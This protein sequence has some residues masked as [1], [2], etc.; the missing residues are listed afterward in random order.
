[1]FRKMM[2][3]F[4]LMAACGL[5]A[6][7]VMIDGVKPGVS[8]MDLAA[9]KEY[10]KNMNLPLFLD[11]TGSDWCGWCKLMQKNVFTKKE[12]TDWAKSRLVLVTID[13]PQN[14]GIVPEKYRE[15]NNAL[16]AL[17]RVSGYPTYVVLD[18]NG[19][20]E[21]GR[22][23]AGEDKTQTSFIA[24]VKALLRFSSASMEKFSSK[25]K[26]TEL[27]DYKKRL[28]EITS[29]R[30]F[31]AEWNRIDPEK[32]LRK[33]LDGLKDI[34]DGYAV[35]VMSKADRDAYN[36]YKAQ[37]SEIKAEM[38]RWFNSSPTNTE[39]NQKKYRDYMDKVNAGENEMEKIVIK[40]IE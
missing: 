40:Y 6:E 10:A 23:G 16:S 38:Q 34:Q 35:S 2:T 5:S 14:S 39:E 3:V 32:A 20:T 25:L 9:A 37:V 21:L 27:E 17:Y 28:T 8:T 1:M 18:A 4:F 29:L 36:R 12:W 22:L 13:F 26:G 15:R 19:E 31:I 11:F 7:S 30:E 33:N 24:E